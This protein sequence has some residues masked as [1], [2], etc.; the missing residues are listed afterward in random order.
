MVGSLTGVLAGLVAITPAAGYV[1][2]LGALAIGL[3]AAVACFS[4]IKLRARMGWDD[5]LDVWG[6]HGVGGIVGSVLTGVFAA[7]NI[8]G[9]SGLLEGNTAQF[10]ANIY[11]TGIAMG[12][13]FAG[14]FV[15]L[16]VMK[17]F[18]TVGVQP[19]AELEGLDQLLHGEDAYEI[20]P[21]YD[22]SGMPS[23]NL[24]STPIA[25]KR[26]LAGKL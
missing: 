12:I 2:P 25:E 21:S 17:M 8:G 5:A 26:V 11:A 14:T 23:L 6:C 16:G 19:E 10:M 7:R 24:S 20:M 4:A 22:I 18:M 3:I 13:G 15:L 9:F 1:S